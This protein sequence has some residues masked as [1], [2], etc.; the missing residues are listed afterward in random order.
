MANRYYTFAQL[1]EKETGVELRAGGTLG[2]HHYIIEKKSETHIKVSGWNTDG[3]KAGET[4]VKIGGSLGY[5]CGSVW[6]IK[7]QSDMTA[8][9]LLRSEFRI[10]KDMVFVIP[11]SEIENIEL[12]EM[13]SSIDEGNQYANHNQFWGCGETWGYRGKNGAFTV[14]HSFHG[15]TDQR[16]KIHRVFI[17]KENYEAGVQECLK[18]LADYSGKSYT[19]IKHP[20]NGLL[21]AP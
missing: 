21:F 3:A 1:S 14:Y 8:I 18:A 12:E 17:V 7:P 13:T 16:R 6:A 2:R 5:N 15:G 19:N 20:A 11:E 4:S 9:E 10:S